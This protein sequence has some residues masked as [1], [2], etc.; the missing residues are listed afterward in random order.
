MERQLHHEVDLLPDDRT[1]SAPQGPFPVNDVAMRTTHRGQRGGNHNRKHAYIHDLRLPFCVAGRK[2]RGH[3]PGGSGW[4]RSNGQASVATRGHPSAR[5]AVQRDPDHRNTVEL[6]PIEGQMVLGNQAMASCCVRALRRPGGLQIVSQ[7]SP[8]QR[9]PDHPSVPV[10]HL[11]SRNCG[12]DP[13]LPHR[14]PPP[15]STVAPL[16]A[17]T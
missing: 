2:D 11:R 16:A 8:L 9:G 6:G 1:V 10:A 5:S 7:A 15:A 13:P 14:P 3:R 4:R 17:A 12:R